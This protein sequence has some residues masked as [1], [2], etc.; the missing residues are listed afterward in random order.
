MLLR[1]LVLIGLAAASLSAAAQTAVD[2]FDRGSYNRSFVGT[3]PGP[4]SHNPDN[5]NYFTGQDFTGMNVGAGY[6]SFFAFDLSSFAGQSITSA[7]LHLFNPIGSFF[8]FNPAANSGPFETLQIFDVATPAATLLSGSGGLA[9]FEDLGTGVSFGTV[10]VSLADNNSFIDI[11][12][13]SDGLAA[14]NAA[15]GGSILFG[16]RLTSI[17]AGAGTQRLFAFS[18]P[19][20]VAMSGTQLLLTATAPIPEPETYAMLVAGLA[21]L[22]FHARRRRAKAVVR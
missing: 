21:L 14:V 18:N 11:V 16:G 3:T 8:Q 2:A 20:M 17:D 22:G 19:D 7:T 15:A 1:S 9:A 5:T 6:R 13:N 12:L 4:V 10:N